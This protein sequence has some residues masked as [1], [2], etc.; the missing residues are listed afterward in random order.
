[1]SR[2]HTIVADPPWEYQPTKADPG[3]YARGVAEAHY[4]TLP[5]SAIA[6]IPVAH[7]VEADAHLYCW[8]TN[9]VLTEQRTKGWSA[10]D[11]VR[12]WGFEPKTLLTWV[13]PGIS[14]GFFFRG[15]TEHVIFAVRGSLPIEPAR[16]ERNW[17]E[18]KK[19]AHSAKPDSFYDLVERVSPGPY[20]EL[21]ARRARF[22]WDYPIGDQALGGAFATAATEPAEG[23]PRG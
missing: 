13:K 16:R 15:A 23:S 6:E 20:A 8:V 7:L 1:M 12:A 19:G 21:F 2:Y 5:L 9:P 22:G 3:G 11:V 4:G 17:F 18:G 14:T 10:V